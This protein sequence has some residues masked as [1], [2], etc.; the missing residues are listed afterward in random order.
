M[1]FQ[2]QFAV[3]SC[4]NQLIPQQ[5]TN[6]VFFGP[7]NALSQAKFLQTN[8]IKFFV[9]VGIPTARVAQYCQSLPSDQCLVVNYDPLFD[10][11]AAVSTIDQELVA[12]YMQ[13]QSASL[14]LLTAQV[15]AQ[16]EANYNSASGLTPQPELEQSLYHNAACYDCNV[17]TA[18]N[19]ELFERFNDLLTIFRLSNAG[20]VLVFSSSGN[21]NDLASLLI[22]HVLHTNGQTTVFEA[23]QYVRS[24]RPSI[25]PNGL[26]LETSGPGLT[27]FA[28]KLRSRQNYQDGCNDSIADSSFSSHATSLATKRRNMPSSDEEDES[29][30]DDNESANISFSSLQSVRA[31]SGTPKARKISARPSGM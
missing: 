28:E 16:T 29:F 15:S 17:I 23:L 14:K 3:A 13:I 20:N 8:N 31:A 11:H 9:A 30:M 5:L 19:A 18:E 6:T 4:K 2:N 7:L 25:A 24:L 27:H 1:S 12:R 22:S 10:P 21:E 26:S